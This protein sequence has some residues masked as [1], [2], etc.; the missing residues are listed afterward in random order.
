MGCVRAQSKNNSTD[1]A[2]LI[3]AYEPPWAVITIVIFC[4]VKAVVDVGA[5]N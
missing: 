1:T 5:L 3:Y 2:L 4:S